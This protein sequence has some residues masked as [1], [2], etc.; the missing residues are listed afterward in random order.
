M[1]PATGLTIATSAV[2]AGHLAVFGLAL[3][4]RAVYSI[5]P[6]PDNVI[7]L[8]AD[9]P[10]WMWLHLAA[11]LLQV[12]V[13]L[14][15]RARHVA[16]YVSVS[17]MGTWSLL[18]L[19]WGLSVPRVSLLGPALGLIVAVCAGGTTVAWADRGARD[20]RRVRP[21]GRS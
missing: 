6:P 16:G 10:W 11:G 15:R 17:V 9:K 13:L 7:A 12:A 14:L 4:G 18:L 5:Q 21:V 1:H 19:T 20:R 8:A 2:A 3:G